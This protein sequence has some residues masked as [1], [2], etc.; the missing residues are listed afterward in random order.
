MPD[1][2]LFVEDSAQEKFL[3]AMLERLAR[4]AAVHLTVRIRT[5]SGGAGKV[6]VQLSQFLKEAEE[7]RATLPDGL[8]IAI[9]ANCK[10]Y[11]SRRKLA[12]DRAAKRE[13]RV[14]YAI[15]DPHIE[16]W[17]LLDSEAFKA[18]LG[19]GCSA[20]DAKCEKE[21]Y[22]KLLSEAVLNAGVQPLLGGIE[23]AEDLAAEYH[24]QRVA[25]HDPSFG[26]FVS[27]FRTW[28]NR[29]RRPI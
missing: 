19:R 24:V 11:N 18:A 5:A 4:E 3:R 13:D 21:R 28:L 14:I 26:R 2:L 9:D 23:Y 10:G 20:P 7:S 17:F 8:V 12:H 27:E 1:I 29:V 25:D 22:K 16:R 6:L 15:P